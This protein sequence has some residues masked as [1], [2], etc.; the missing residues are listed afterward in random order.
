MFRAQISPSIQLL[1][2]ACLIPL[3]RIQLLVSRA[4]ESQLRWEAELGG[5]WR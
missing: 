1:E 2:W 5:S 4:E 3:E